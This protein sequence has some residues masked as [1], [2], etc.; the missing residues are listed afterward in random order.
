MC[1]GMDAST[2]RYRLRDSAR[3]HD[4]SLFMNVAWRVVVS[5]RYAARTLK[6]GQLGC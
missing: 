1:Y 3:G 4:T 6:A 2:A 5:N